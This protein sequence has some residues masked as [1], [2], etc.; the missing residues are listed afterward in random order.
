MFGNGLNLTD[1]RMYRRDDRVICGGD[2]E[3]QWLR[4]AVEYRQAL[5]DA[6]DA[7][8]KPLR[9]EPRRLPRISLFRR[10]AE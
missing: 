10:A 9:R 1:I 8:P 7:T 5:A 6:R 4:R 2:P 3:P